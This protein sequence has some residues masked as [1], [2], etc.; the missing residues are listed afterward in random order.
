LTYAE[1]DGF[2]DFAPEA[3]SVLA[4][5]STTGISLEARRSIA[6]QQ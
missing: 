6:A 4:D 1:R 2:F 5:S 3:L